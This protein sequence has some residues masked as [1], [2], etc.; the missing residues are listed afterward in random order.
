MGLA[1]RIFLKTVLVFLGLAAALASGLY[2]WLGTEAGA[3]AVFGRL[4]SLAAEEGLTL[5]ARSFEGPLPRRLKAEGLLVEDGRGF[6]FQAEAVEVELSP[7]AL[8]TGQVRLTRV[9]LAGPALVLPPA[10][11]AGEAPLPR[12]PLRLRLDELVL[13]GGRLEAEPFNRAVGRGDLELAAGLAWHPESGLTANILKLAGARWHWPEGAEIMGESWLARG[14]F[15]VSPDGPLVLLLERFESGGLALSGR[16]AWNPGPAGGDLS[17]DIEAR[18][19]D[20]APLFPGLSGPVSAGLRGGGRPLEL[21]TA[22]VE[23][24]S[25]G[26]TT[27]PGAWTE[28]ALEGEV[29]CAVKAAAGPELSGR[30]ALQAGDSPG[31]P[32]NF[33]GHWRFQP[34][35]DLVLE[36]LD[37][38]AAGLA[39]AGGLKIDLAGE[40][41]ALNGRL[42]GEAF[43]A[44][45]SGREISGGPARL[46]LGLDSAGGQKADLE[47]DLEKLTLGPPA[48]PDLALAKTRARLKAVDLF[49]RRDL[50]LNLGLGPGQAGGLAWTQGEIRAE[51]RGG[52]GTWRLDLLSAAAGPDR[53]TAGGSF[54]PS[55]AEVTRLDFKSGPSGLKL[56]APVTLAWGEDLKISPVKARLLPAG[57]MNLIAK[58][59]PDE[60]NLKAEI[61]KLPYRFLNLFTR[62][63]LPEGQFQSLNLDLG[64]RGRVY[65]GKFTLKASLSPGGS[66][67]RLTPELDLAGGLEGQ[68]LIAQGNLTGGPGWPAA[69]KINLRLPLTPG[70]GEAPPRPDLKGALSGRLDFSGPLEP[71][72]RLAG[73]PDRTLSGQALAGLDLAGSLSRPSLAGSLRLTGGRYEDKVLGLWLRD[74]SLNAESRPDQSLRVALA[75]RDLGRGELNL[76]GEIRDLARPVLKAEGRL[77][78]F[79]PFRRDD[80]SLT[81][82]GGLGLAGTLDRLTVT[83][84]LTLEEGGLDLNLVAG[85]GSIATLPVDETSEPDASAEASLQLDLK[86]NAPGRF[87]I[88]GLGLDSE[89]RG[90]LRVKGPPGRRLALSGDMR[91]VRGWYEPPVFNRK[92]DFENGRIMF[93]GDLFPYL[94]L[95]L[96]NSTPDLTAIIKITGPA[97]QPEV[98]LTSRPPLNQDE[99]VGRLLFGKSPSSISRLEA[100][101]LAAVLKEL[102]NFGGD[103]INPVKTVR[104]S[105]GLDV[106]R[107]GG[108]SAGHGERQVS[109]L[110]GSLASE[111]NPRAGERTADEAVAVEAGKYISDN[112]YMGVEHDKDGPAVRLEVELSPSFSLEARSSSESSQVG[113]GWK[114]DY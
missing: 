80:L 8:L 105:L 4:Q 20:L 90:Q 95:E 13:T 89:W 6:L 73:M 78:S 67:G 24:R 41:P 14:N 32:L 101:Q 43:P 58:L 55:A 91:P 15:S 49:G 103:I 9:L 1:G 65:S 104:R 102:T 99:V 3:R 38:K 52:Q 29:N 98:R 70:P 110:S 63:A 85:A 18:L 93:T 17:L 42:T 109:D 111:M 37:L 92:F 35:G 34:P 7:A 84:D 106:L 77:Q 68:A 114:K 10:D 61:K 82:S 53:L 75:G 83:S 45:W 46:V 64:R 69:G 26:L 31:G 100:L 25:P 19:E 108:G 48:A 107:L 44:A 21:L 12:C 36:E 72:W 76:A 51:A 112:I 88:T 59:G 62:A 74:L 16:T 71:L 56:V 50:N 60:F 22:K 47:V 96:T 94:D 27:P 79:K 113:L 87:Q 86:V 28:L 57:E 30:L 5:A 11:P 66:F 39:L 81:L 33:N 97:R 54:S 40:E 23:A 2:L